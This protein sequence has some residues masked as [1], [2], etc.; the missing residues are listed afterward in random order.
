MDIRGLLESPQGSQ[1]SS[2]VGECTYAFLPSCSSSVT[3]PFARIKGSVAFPR[4]FPTRL[5][6]RAI[7]RATGCESNL[8]LKVE[9]VQGKQVSLEWTETSWGLWEGW[10][11]PGVRLFLWG[12]V[13]NTHPEICLLLEIL[14]IINLLFDCNMWTLVGKVTCKEP[15]GEIT[16][17]WLP[18]E[19]LG[20]GW[21][22]GLG[23]GLEK[24]QIPWL[25]LE[26]SDLV[27]PG[28][29]QEYVL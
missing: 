6:H 15:E 18:L 7:P 14:N 9:A 24:V 16:T 10:R 23:R 28:G 21:R 12:V 26:N 11:D 3:L 19:V 2:R 29:T 1:S 17:H 8:G 13:A 5:S 22:V 25:Y 4:G 27:L 20:A